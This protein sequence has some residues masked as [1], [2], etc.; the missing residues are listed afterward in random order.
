MWIQN[1]YQKTKDEWSSFDSCSFIPN[2]QTSYG[3]G[4]SLYWQENCVLEFYKM[5]NINFSHQVKK[6][7]Q[8]LELELQNKR[9]KFVTSPVS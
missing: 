4:K 2:K 7:E 9:H 5:F 6:A 8:E 1:E 3:D